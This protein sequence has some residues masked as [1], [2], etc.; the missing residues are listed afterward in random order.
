MNHKPVLLFH[1]SNNCSSWMAYKIQPESS[2][3]YSI[4]EHVQEL[5]YDT[6]PKMAS[7][8]YILT[9]SVIVVVA[10]VQGSFGVKVN[11]DLT[12]TRSQKQ[13][14]DRVSWSIFSWRARN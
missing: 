1:Y 2:S 14:L 6:R 10:L 7:Y 12:L 3:S 11:D 13:A 4:V 5:Q 9:F 8:K